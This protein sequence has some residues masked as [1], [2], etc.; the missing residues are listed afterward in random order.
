MILY[1]TVLTLLYFILRN[2]IDLYL[3]FFTANV[4]YGSH[5][6]YGSIYIPP[7]TVQVNDNAKIILMIIFIGIILFTMIVDRIENNKVKKY[8]FQRNINISKNHA[9]VILLISLIFFA[10]VLSYSISK[11]IISK[12]DLKSGIPGMVLT[13]FYYFSALSFIA[14]FFLGK[15]L[16][17]FLSAI[18]LVFIIVASARIYP[19]LA[20]IS[21]VIIKYNGRKLIS[22]NTVKL[23][24]ISTMVLLITVVPR[25]GKQMIEQAKQ[26]N[27]MSYISVVLGSYE[28]GQ[29]SYNLNATTSDE[30]T[31]DHTLDAVLF[32]AIP[33]LHRIIEYKPRRF[34]VYIYRDLNP[35][36]NYGLG[37]TFWGESYVLGGFPGV[38]AFLFIV[39]L[40]I[41]IINKRIFLGSVYYPFYIL[42]AVYLAFYLP[43]NDILLIIA[44]F[45]NLLFFSVFYIIIYSF[46]SAVGKGKRIELR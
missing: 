36:F 18:Q 30:Y 31:S 12:R 7:Y 25:Y 9:K 2:K 15:K 16:Y 45:K 28:I 10:I 17:I 4:L 14:S 38:L 19:I 27:F 1:V 3:L 13:L 26:G 32:G 23:V 37:G 8:V 43:R 33:L 41:N 21:C 46:V 44:T 6:I 35:G 39:L 5:V 42:T 20:L 22:K 40:C 34:S 11:G 29:I 24:L